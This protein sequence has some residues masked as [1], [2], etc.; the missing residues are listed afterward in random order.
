MNRNSLRALMCRCGTLSKSLK[1]AIT[2]LLLCLT[3]YTGF[4]AVVVTPAPNGGAVCSITA[5]SPTNVGTITITEGLQNDFPT[6]SSSIVLAPPTGWSFVGVLPTITSAAGNDVTIG[7]TSI[8]SGA[9]TINFNASGIT[10]TDVITISNLQVQAASSSSSAGNIFAQTDLGIAGIS[11]GALGTNFGSLAIVAA[12]VPSLTISG[13]P[14]GAICAGTG[15]TFLPTPINGGTSPT[16]QWFVN[17]VSVGSAAFYSTSTL[18]NGNTVN[19]ILTS[20]GTVCVSPLTATSNTITV[21]VNALPTVVTASG[22]GTFCG[23]TTISAANGG[24]GIIYFQGNTTGGISTATPSS[25]QVVSASGTYYFR[26]QSAA[27]CWGP[28]GSVSVV[29]NPTP[30]AVT[31]TGGGSF[32]GGTTTL[33]ASNGGD[34]VIYYQGTTSNGVSVATPSTSQVIGATGTYFFRALLGGCWSVQGSQTVTIN[35]IP[36]TVVASGAGTFCGSTTVS[37][38]NGGS[39]TI[40]FQGNTAGGTSTA[41]PASSQVVSTSGTYYFRAQG[42]GGCWGTEG[43]VAV[44]INPAATAN[45]GLPQS[46]CAG[47][48]TTLTGA[49]GGSA[50]TSTWTA[51]SG[52]FGAP[53]S[54]TSTYTPTIVG[55]SVV[56]TLTTNDPDGAGPCAAAVSTATITVSAQPTIVTVTGGGTFCGFTTISAANGGSGT[57]YFQGTTSG[58]TSTATPSTFQPISTSGTYFFRAQSG[59]GCWG[60]Q[61]STT[62]TVNPL[63]NPYTVTGGGGYCTGGTGS[64]I[65]LSNSDAGVNYQL[66]RF[67]VNVGA[68]IAGTNAPLDFGLQTIAGTY[69]VVAT[70]P[71]TGCSLTM[72]GS[73][74][75][76]INALPTA[77]TV[78]GTGSYCVGGTGVTITQSGSSAGVNYQLKLG[79]LPVGSPV[80]GSGSSISFGAQTAAGTYTATATNATTG[81]INNMLGSATVTINALP[82]AFSVTGGGGY[83]SGGTGLV[84]GLGGSTLGVSYQLIK[85][86][87]P[88]GAPVSGTGSAITF[89][90]QTSAA[91]YTVVA[92]NLATL[93][94]NNMTGSAVIIINTPP[95]AFTVNGGGSYCSGGSGV[96]VGLSGSV[97][98]VNYQLYLNGIASGA[99]MAGTGAAL[100][101]GLQTGAGTFTVIATD[102]A[103]LCTSNMTGSVI[104]SINALPTAFLIIGGGSYCTGGAGVPVGLA[105]S[106]AGVSYQLYLSFAPLGSPIAGT[107]SAITW[108]LQM[109]A[110][111]YTVIATNN[112]TGCTNNMTGGV[113][114]SILPLPGVFSVTGGGGYCIG[115]TGAS[116]GLTGSEVGVD[117]LLYLGIVPVGIPVAG[118]G[119]TLDFG[120]QTTAGVYTV[121]ATSASTTCVNIMTGS[122][123]IMVNPLPG[124]FNVTGGGAYCAG[125]TG[126]NVGLSGSTAGIDY[127]L[128]NGGI[129]TGA[130]VAGTGGFIDFGPQ[131]AAGTYTV[132]ATD[133]VTGCT[134][135]MT[136]SSLVTINPLPIVNNVTG[137]GM[138]C[139]G[140]G[141][142]S[143]GLDN[144]DFGFDY[145]LYNSGSLVT[146]LGG[147]GGALDFGFITTDGI[148]TVVAVDLSTGCSNT[149]NGSATI[150]T[151]PLPTVFNI[152]ADGA[153]CA[154]GTGVDITLDGSETGVDYQ[155][156]LGGFSVGGALISGTGLALDF[157]LQTAA[158]TYT[159]VGN[160]PLASCTSNMAGTSTITINIAPSV[161]NVTGG[162]DYCIGGTG[163]S[164]GLD[165]SDFGVDY[166]LYNGTTAVGGPMTGIGGA[167]DFGPQTAIGTYTI[168]ANDPFITCP[169]T[170]AGSAIIGTV[171]FPV[172]SAI[173]GPAILCD[174]TS[175][176][177]MDVTAGGVWSSGTP[178]IIVV[179]TGG[180]VTGVGGGTGTVS[181][182]VTNTTGC[183]TSVTTL[184]DVLATPAVALITGATDVCAGNTITLSNATVGTHTWS[185]S[186]S[187]IATVGSTGIVT[188]VAAGLVTI[189][190]TVTNGSGCSSF[191][192]FDM[193]IGAGIPLSAILPTGSATLCHGLPVGLSVSTTGS[194]SGLTYQWFQDGA[195]ILGANTD[196]DTATVP[197]LYTVT[198]RNGTCTL[199]LTGTNIIAPPAP[200]ISLDT[201]PN[202]LFTGSFVTYQWLLNGAIIPGATANNTPQAGTFGSIYQVAVSD[203][204]GCTDTSGAFIVSDSI[205]LNVTTAQIAANIRIYP[206]PV[207]S[208][209]NIEAP[210]KV[211]VSIVS[212][213]GSVLIDRKEAISINVARLASG[214]YMVMIY[215]ENNILIKTDKFIKMD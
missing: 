131:T 70:N 53:G 139:A 132:V 202:L 12:S 20:G 187:T 76:S 152:S 101:F 96:H 168:V 25:S 99:A 191:A 22:G 37:A 5:T 123:S 97:S 106:Q 105:N 182:T 190:Y 1:L 143:V 75:V 100:D 82:I 137:G 113:A 110:G 6:G 181:Y 63:P 86:G 199:T 74:I 111:F 116:V 134:N 178:S 73:A 16:Y 47:S 140:S 147:I 72:G 156:Y 133:A 85:S 115:G 207:T 32:C 210:V 91:T 186:N 29:I 193:T 9:L 209:L 148:Y 158:G 109:T 4:S 45:A 180:V 119:V 65:G 66:Q 14:S 64:D 83:C 162:G 208:I 98:G 10:R 211:L 188:G 51:A 24:S 145:A 87:V 200:I 61:G 120:P 28:E 163:S 62:V 126:M 114:V 128:M 43:S 23:N 89:G 125:G 167:L 3:N 197:G 192:T 112:I 81:C 33:N 94:T 108:G 173:T 185:S 68:A 78:S 39:G 161:Y 55:G 159:I 107:G 57:I 118:T 141:G 67:A 130:A 35:T 169:A 155:L 157:G 189:T 8:S 206:N 195:P 77:F 52:T 71:T 102:P 138:Y 179:G 176:T 103:T 46:I 127:Q 183:A 142:L 150:T 59:G 84:V 80:A 122:V 154:G 11:T 205:K 88:S 60:P 90:L 166:Q 146:T 165:N 175:A 177:L 196:V 164:I 172:V 21:S 34:G 153:Y 48:T 18:A 44:T 15:V 95:T 93:C 135:N 124:L 213:D 13:T 171:A 42:A 19:A 92:T 151:I 58:G 174:G 215:D 117:Y 41:T 31:V 27:G 144:S 36:T 79:G 2:A 212:P 121:I 49:I 198:I 56:L 214:M 26:A 204:N 170:M 40:Y 7:V 38:A 194:P 136:G 30:S 129:S 54:P 149:M 201:I 184:V 69:T 17:G 104:S 203:A 160:N 50:T